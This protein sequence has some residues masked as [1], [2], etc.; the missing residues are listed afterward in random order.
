KKPLNPAF[1][2]LKSLHRQLKQNQQLERLRQEQQRRRQLQTQTDA[3]L[4][5]RWARD[6][7]PLP[8]TDRVVH[9]TSS[10]EPL[11]FQR[12]ADDDDVAEWL[13]E[14]DETLSSRRAGLGPDVV[15]KLRRGDWTV[16]A[17]IDL[18]GLRVDEAREAVGQFLRECVKLEK[19]CVR[20]IHGKGLGSANRK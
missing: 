13:L 18:H 2:G 6:V 3:E 20:I 1:A 10:P 15:R 12:W 11:P 5:R 4:F 8:T 17:Q 19:R 16:T 14:T 7:V 9:R